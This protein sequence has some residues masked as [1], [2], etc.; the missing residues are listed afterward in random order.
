MPGWDGSTKG[1]RRF[2]QL[3]A[4]ARAYIARLEAVSGVRAAI[5]STGSERDDT[6]LRDD[7]MRIADLGLRILA[8][9]TRRLLEILSH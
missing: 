2:D 4:A 8:A 6:I 3:P 7:V 9:F 5:V 1:L